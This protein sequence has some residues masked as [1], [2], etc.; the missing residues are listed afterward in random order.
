MR[1]PQKLKTINDVPNYIGEKT[2]YW[3]GFLVKRV[4]LV[5]RG[6]KV[7]EQICISKRRNCK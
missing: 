7:A 6:K 2:Y 4:T 3:H 5:S 1:I